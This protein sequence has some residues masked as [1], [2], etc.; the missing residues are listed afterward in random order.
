MRMTDEQVFEGQIGSAQHPADVVG[1]RRHVDGRC[2]VVVDQKILI[3]AAV[4]LVK[5]LKAEIILALF[6]HGKLFFPI[7]TL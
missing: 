1:R 5:C 6:P 4:R 3:F 2:L 7:R